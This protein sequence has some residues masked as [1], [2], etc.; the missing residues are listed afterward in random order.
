M[1][2]LTE[3]SHVEVFGL[4][5]DRIVQHTAVIV[6]ILII[7]LQRKRDAVVEIRDTGGD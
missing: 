4:V 1:T 5:A 3:F 2:W 7:H 6:E